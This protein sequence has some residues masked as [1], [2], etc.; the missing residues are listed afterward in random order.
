MGA[1]RGNCP[2]IYGL[3]G[4]ELNLRSFQP[5]NLQDFFLIVK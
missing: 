4:E 5:I 1:S 2:E 3:D